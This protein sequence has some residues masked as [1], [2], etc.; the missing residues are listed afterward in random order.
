MFS[1]QQADQT[2]LDEVGRLH[3]T[4]GTV[5]DLDASKKKFPKLYTDTVD[6]VKAAAAN[7]ADTSWK[8]LPKPNTVGW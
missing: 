1:Q 4:G 7:P 3:P 8:N 2:F 5:G 6:K